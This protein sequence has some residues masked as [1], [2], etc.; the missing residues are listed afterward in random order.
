M[1]S[2]TSTAGQPGA[3]DSTVNLERPVIKVSER[4]VE[5]LEELLKGSS[6]HF[7]SSF[8]RQVESQIMQSVVAAVDAF[9]GKAKAMLAAQWEESCGGSE[10]C[11]LM[12]ILVKI[13]LNCLP[14]LA[15]SLVKHAE[16]I[17][18]IVIEGEVDLINLSAGHQGR[19][20][21][22]RGASNRTKAKLM[23]QE[24]SERC[25][26]IVSK[27]LKAFA[28]AVKQNGDAA[29][30]AA[31]APLQQSANLH[32]LP[33]S[34]RRQAAESGLVVSKGVFLEHV[35]SLALQ[36]VDS[37]ALVEDSSYL[38][39]VPMVIG[40]AGKTTDMKRI[41][42]GTAS[43]P[44]STRASLHAQ[45]LI[46][47]AE[48]RRTAQALPGG[49]APS[50]NVSHH[51]D[52]AY[53]ALTIE[54]PPHVETVLRAREQQLA[55]LVHEVHGYNCVPAMYATLTNAAGNQIIELDSMTGDS[56][57][58]DA[59]TASEMANQYRFRMI[60]ADNGEILA[61]RYC[62]LSPVVVLLLIQ[63]KTHVNGVVEFHTETMNL[64]K[65]PNSS[66][67]SWK[68]LDTGVTYDTVI[69]SDV[70]PS[71]IPASTAAASM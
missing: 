35:V 28:D 36:V 51:D 5:A 67:S 10:Y 6:M 29:V 52:Q 63:T 44:L 16:T 25:A 37:A 59:A 47:L 38:R 50:A 61:G 53:T 66:S 13:V 24:R 43:G 65:D 62:R 40:D 69:P 1:G 17:I 56:T 41:T 55:R 27:G 32:S 19:H 31:L 8:L 3:T 46:S 71:P 68:N 57:G 12:G 9:I 18:S 48:Q 70:K 21:A 49:L 26:D 20:P 30:R 54:T 39:Q 2:A 14:E 22:A 15:D 42:D 58:A 60:N 23:I 33:P 45:R 4:E 34:Q 7:D 11:Y 64:V